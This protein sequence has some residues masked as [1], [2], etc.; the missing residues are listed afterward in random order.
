VLAGGSVVD[1]VRVGLA[2][3]CIQAGIGATNDLVD[4]ERDAGQKPGKPIP[5]GLVGRGFAQVVAIGAFAVGL[6]L[7]AGS[8]AT[9][10]FLG[11]VTIGIGLLYDLRLK[12]TAWSW[13][14]FAIGI[15]ILPIFG[16]L[17]VTDSL[18][19]PFL[20]LVPASVVAGAALAIANGAADVERDRAAGISSIATEL[21]PARAWL[22]HAWLLASVAAA[23]WVTAAVSGASLFQLSVVAAASVVSSA[24]AVAGRGGGPARRERA[25]ELEAIGF[26]VLAVAWGWAVLA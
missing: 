17:G 4:A 10:V 26:A 12:G 23:A 8:G 24:A 25:W 2:M 3:L 13:L 1:V 19:A 7:A 18:P 14:P 15:P 21:G 22:V 11:A 9:L 6:M 16:W 5:R 20:V